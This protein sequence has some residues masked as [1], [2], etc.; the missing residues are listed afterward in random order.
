[1][2]K[3]FVLIV[4]LAVIAGC[5]GGGDAPTVVDQIVDNAGTT[6]TGT[7]S[8]NPVDCGNGV[9]D[10]G[11]VCDD[12]N[13]DPINSTA[14]SCNST[15]TE[16]LR[17]PVNALMQR[18][19]PGAMETISTGQGNDIA[20]ASCG[21]TTAVLAGGVYS[22]VAANHDCPAVVSLT[23]RYLTDTGVTLDN[24]ISQG[25]NYSALC[26]A[27]NAE[28]TLGTTCTVT[29]P[30]AGAEKEWMAQQ[31]INNGVVILN[32]KPYKNDQGQV[33]SEKG[34]YILIVGF[35]YGTTIDSGTFK[36]TDVAGVGDVL[37]PTG[38]IQMQAVDID[39]LMDGVEKHFLL[40]ESI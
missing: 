23:Q 30:T 33:V 15:C 9:L 24:Y 18:D 6:G 11:E 34:H 19:C 2:K 10:T 21:P 36:V 26:D 3:L 17:T 31:L 4:C 1:M 13:N 25:S 27:I 7:S 32:L 37:N 40:I 22:E 14:D 16:I 35:G 12:G 20:A 29:T 5:G 28:T 39:M 38:I 8:G